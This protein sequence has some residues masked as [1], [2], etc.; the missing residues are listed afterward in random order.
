LTPGIFLVPVF[1]V[2]IPLLNRIL[3]KT[4]WNL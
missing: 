3:S 4:N 1:A 2:F